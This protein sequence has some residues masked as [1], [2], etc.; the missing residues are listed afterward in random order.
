M[1]S[2]GKPAAAKPAED[3]KT[4]GTDK[5]DA[6]APGATKPVLEKKTS[7]ETHKL[8]PAKPAGTASKL[9]D[10]KQASDDKSDAEAFVYEGLLTPRFTCWAT[11]LTTTLTL[12]HL[13]NCIA[14]CRVQ[15][16]RLTTAV[17]R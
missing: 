13:L 15:K 2:K 4:K 6:P 5:V 11:C 9:K 12:T 3:F 14:F 17:M 7:A 1:E 16:W 10:S 8:T